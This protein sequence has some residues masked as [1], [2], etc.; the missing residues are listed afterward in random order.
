MTYEVP[1]LNY[2]NQIENYVAGS[3]AMIMTDLKSPNTVK[4]CD[5]DI[6]IS[7]NNGVDK[8]IF[9]DQEHFMEW[10]LKWT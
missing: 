7:I 4:F 5:E 2:K 1:Y 3:K 9:R 8:L 6:R 10:I